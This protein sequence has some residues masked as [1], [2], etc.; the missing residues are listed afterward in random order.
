[1]ETPP[2]MLLVSLVLSATALPALSADPPVAALTKDN[3][4]AAEAAAAFK[5]QITEGK[6][7]YARRFELLLPK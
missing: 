3:P 7:R 1:M 6:W 4:G 5:A 2:R